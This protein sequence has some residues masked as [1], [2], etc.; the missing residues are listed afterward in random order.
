MTRMTPRAASAPLRDVAPPGRFRSLRLFRAFRTEQSDPEGFYTLL[1][2]DAAHQIERH[3]T[4]ADR[5]VV[6]IGGGGGYFTA[7]FGRRG[8]RCVLVEPDPAELSS[9]GAPYPDAVVGDGLRLPLRDGSLD[10]SFSSNVL[11]HVPDP[12]AFIDEML[13]VTRP[14]GVVYLS[15]TLWLSPWGGHETSPWHFL[16]GRYA[17]RRYA[18]RH[19]HPPK[20]RYGESLFAV[21]AGRVLRLVRA[22]ADVTVL[23]ARPRYYPRWCAFFVRLPLLRELLTWNLLLILR[24]EQQP[25]DGPGVRRT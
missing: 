16:G 2:A 17:A 5:T 20:N 6:D 9:R 19:G 8:A 3:V 21:S 25:P 22:R 12:A 10:V 18:R 7:A 15:Y 4:L 24:R 14:G 23:E 1:A 11:E 13:R